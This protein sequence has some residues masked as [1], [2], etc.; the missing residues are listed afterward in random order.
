MVQRA[1]R[2]P[3]LPKELTQHITLQLIARAITAGNDTFNRSRKRFPRCRQWT[4][5]DNHVETLK[6]E[7][8]V[9][10]GPEGIDDIS[11]LYPFFVEFG[12]V[13]GDI[14]IAPHAFGIR[15]DRHSITVQ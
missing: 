7:S 5:T 14:S 8:Y 12:R 13:S 2:D 4:S 6:S 3:K 11:D 1:A 9:D 10:A 15:S